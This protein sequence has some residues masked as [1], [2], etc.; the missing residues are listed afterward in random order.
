MI[1]TNSDLDAMTYDALVDMHEKYESEG[2]NTSKIERAMEWRD[3]QSAMIQ[4]WRERRSE[5]KR[6]KKA[7]AK[8]IFDA[9]G[10]YMKVS[11]L[12]KEAK[13]EIKCWKDNDTAK[14][15][16]WMENS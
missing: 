4:M 5:L 1:W 9:N 13:T 8:H 14:A 16:Y 11:Y 12:L 15:R 6:L 3:N 2:K 7:G 10:D